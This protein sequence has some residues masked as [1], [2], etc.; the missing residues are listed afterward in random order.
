MNLRRLFPPARLWVGGILGLAYALALLYV[1]DR[2]T[3]WAGVAV[4]VATVAA[5]AIPYATSGG[6]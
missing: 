1:V 3:F 6:H 4:Y 5:V 2:Y